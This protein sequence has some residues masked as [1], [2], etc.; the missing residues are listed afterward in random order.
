MTWLLELLHTGCGLDKSGW[1]IESHME[2]A[3]GGYLSQSMII[4]GPNDV[5]VA[6]SRQTMMVFG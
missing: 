6:L 5:P 1:T 4:R 2:S 3:I